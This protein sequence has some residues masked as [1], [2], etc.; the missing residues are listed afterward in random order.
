MVQVLKALV[1]GM[2]IL[3]VI[4]MAALG[5]GIYQKA[6]ELDL[7][8]EKTTSQGGFS[9]KKLPIPPDCSVVEMKPDGPRLYL[10]LGPERK[11]AKILIIDTKSGNI[12]GSLKTAP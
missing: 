10:R 5:Y 1:I 8:P 11:C 12:V 3:I 4:G 2:G 9:E 6:T 7:G